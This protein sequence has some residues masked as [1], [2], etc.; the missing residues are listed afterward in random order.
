MVEK[1]RKYLVLGC[2][3]PHVEYGLRNDALAVRDL[4]RNFYANALSPSK[5]AFHFVE[6]ENR[7]DIEN[8]VRESIGAICDRISSSDCIDDKNVF[9]KLTIKW[10]EKYVK[11]ED[12]VYIFDADDSEY[13]VLVAKDMPADKVYSRLRRYASAGNIKLTK[14]SLS[15]LMAIVDKLE[16][17]MKIEFLEKFKSDIANQR[18]DLDLTKNHIERMSLVYNRQAREY[19]KMQIAL[20]E[21]LTKLPDD[22]RL[23]YEMK[24][25]K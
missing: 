10:A 14:R 8:I 23:L 4:P 11:L 3:P 15:M 1:N 7:K 18:E 17:N 2:I 21:Y 9:Y 24:V 22:L 12:Y 5:G 6:I 25:N 13:V 20:D 16:P 19:K